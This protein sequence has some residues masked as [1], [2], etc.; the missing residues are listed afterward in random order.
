[1]KKVV[2]V[3]FEADLYGQG[4]VNMD[5]GDQKWIHL[6]ENTHLRQE[7]SRHGNTSYAKKN[8]YRD[9]NGNLDWKLKISSDCLKKSMFERDILT[10]SPKVTH[11]DDVL[12]SFLFSVP[13]LVKGWMSATKKETLKRKG[14]LTICDAQQTSDSVSYLEWFSKSGEKTSNDAETEMSDNTIFKKETVGDITYKTMGNIDIMRLQFISCD[15]SLDRYNFNPDKFDLV[16]RYLSRRLP[17]FNSELGFYKIKN[18]SLELPEKGFELS[19]ENVVFLVKE[20]LKRILSLNVERN[21]S[22]AKTS[23]LRVKLVENPL[24]DTHTSKDNWIEINTVQDI[25]NLN[26]D[27]ASFF[28]PVDEDEANDLRESIEMSLNNSVNKAKEVAREK[29][30]RSKSKTSKENV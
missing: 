6:R 8:F 2:N 24:F 13:S 1:M 28:L 22:F 5:S 9:S 12:Y 16:K 4:I 21:N 7:N 23:A 17:N 25:E 19:N 10:Q 20:T 30:E 26:F 11:N 27:V 15:Q 3:L 14:A 18:S 29:R